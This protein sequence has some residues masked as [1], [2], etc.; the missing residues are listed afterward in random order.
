[1]ENRLE[2]KSAA[3][4]MG[5]SRKFKGG[6]NKRFIIEDFFL[7]YVGVRWCKVGVVLISLRFEPDLLGNA[8]FVGDRR[9][10]REEAAVPLRAEQNQKFHSLRSSIPQHIHM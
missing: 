8:G 3:A 2:G 7:S 4:V 6:D 5:E 9:M 1:M 10:E